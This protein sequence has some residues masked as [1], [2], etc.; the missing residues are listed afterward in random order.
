MKRVWFTLL[1]LIV[2]SGNAF[3]HPVSFKKGYGIMPVYTDKRREIELNYS[4]THNQAFGVHAIQLDD[5][6]ENIDLFIPHFNYRAWR[7]NEMDSQ[8]NLYFVGGIGGAER[9]SGGTP[10]GM[11]L[12]QA[13]YETRRIYTLLAGERLELE[14]GE[15]FSLLRGRV[16]VAPYLADFEDFHTWLIAQVEYTPELEDELTVT[17]MFRFFY[18]SYLVETGISTRGGLYA[19]GI[20]HF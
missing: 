11:A 9:Q 8:T 17:P 5:R 20:F 16:G 4:F 15:D 7:R 13:D 3:A 10:A 12:V 18:K 2:P 19:G 1:I 6:D 14:G